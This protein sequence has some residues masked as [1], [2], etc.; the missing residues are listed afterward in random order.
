[1]QRTNDIPV[2]Y[3]DSRVFDP[4]ME[5]LANA[6]AGC[7]GV[8]LSHIRG[9]LAA[10]WEILLEMELTKERILPERVFFP[11]GPQI[12]LAMRTFN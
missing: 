10:Y 9:C 4:T 6:I 3:G 11:S 1:M 7:P 8:S 5:A 12:E 2:F